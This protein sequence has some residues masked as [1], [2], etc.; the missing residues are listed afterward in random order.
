MSAKLWAQNNRKAFYHQPIRAYQLLAM[1]AGMG[2]DI[3]GIL[4]GDFD[5]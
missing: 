3:D 5:L 4:N 1:M 2:V